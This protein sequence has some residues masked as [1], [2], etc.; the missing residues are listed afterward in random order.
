MYLY[1]GGILY[2]AQKGTHLLKAF[3]IKVNQHLD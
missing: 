2:R 1:K 3:K